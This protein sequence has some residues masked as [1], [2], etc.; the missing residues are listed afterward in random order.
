MSYYKGL[1]YIIITISFIVF[2]TL[3]LQKL[4]I[5]ENYSDVD[6]YSDV[7]IRSFPESIIEYQQGV[8]YNWIYDHFDKCYIIY[9]DKR[10][11]SIE[12]LFKYLNIE[13]TMFS[14]IHKDI[15][16][17]DV[18]IQN[19]LINE[20][21]SLNMGRIAC[22][23]SH[24]YVLQEFLKNDK[25]QT[26]IIFEDDLAIPKNLNRL[27]KR[28]NKAMKDLPKDWD[29]IN[30]GGC[31]DTCN[32]RTRITNELFKSTRA[33][34]RHCYGVSKNGARIILSNTLPMSARP[35]DF[36]IN[37]LSEKGLLNMYVTSPSL[38]F[39]NREDF[40]TNLGNTALIQKECMRDLTNKLIN[41]EKRLSLLSKDNVN[42]SYGIYYIN[43]INSL[44]K[45]NYMQSQFDK[46]GLQNINR[47]EQYQDNYQGLSNVLSHKKAINQFNI[48]KFDYGLILHDNIGIYLLY[49]DK[50]NI[51]EIVNTAPEDWDII[52][53]YDFNNYY[54][55]D[56]FNPY[57]SGS[58]ILGYIINNT[59]NVKN[60]DKNEY[61]S[62]DEILTDL[63]TYSFETNLLYKS[64]YYKDHQFYDDRSN[65]EIESVSII[66]NVINS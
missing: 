32:T 22:H 7:T 20:D 43:S 4:N 42:N 41:L 37:A 54:G 23:L 55:D 24:L 36:S 35:G 45:D 40:G 44:D 2:I 30:F 29:I 26:C 1:F 66:N 52:L 58:E 61:T 48:D 14:A 63:N 11:E 8:K 38:F 16:Q 31:W 25:L 3:L 17:R 57:E 21:S 47:I 56:I 13:P 28:F 59:I 19:N 50:Y 65:D 39:Q 10:K 6:K 12:K 33:Q 46:I 27:V 15:I 51:D 49:I 60:I 62:L 34:C 9:L 53:L 64:N 18:L 5:I